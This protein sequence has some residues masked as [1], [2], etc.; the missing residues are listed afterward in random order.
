MQETNMIILTAC[1]ALLYMGFMSQVLKTNKT[2]EEE[3]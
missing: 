3:D 2:E 1:I